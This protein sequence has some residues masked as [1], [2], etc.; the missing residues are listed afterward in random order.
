MLDGSDPEGIA[1]K[2]GL[3]CYYPQGLPH[4]V[5]RHRECLIGMFNNVKL[6]YSCLCIFV[7]CTF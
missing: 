3:T 1:T 4:Y 5:I 6:N 7:L 2:G